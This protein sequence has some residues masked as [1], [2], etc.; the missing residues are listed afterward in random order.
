MLKLD[1]YHYL[2]AGLPELEFNTNSYKKTL[3]EYRN[4]LRKELL[5]NDFEL[6]KILMHEIDNKNLLNI[7][8][9]HPERFLIGGNYSYEELKTNT[10]NNSNLATYLQ[11][12]FL[13]DPFQNFPEK[14]D[15]YTH[16]LFN[17]YNEFT[18]KTKNSFLQLWF[19]FN[20][21]LR[22]IILILNNEK[23]DNGDVLLDKNKTKQ[24]IEKY[25]SKNINQKLFFPWFEK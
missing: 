2:I 25:Q 7:L 3:L 11:D 16:E 18:H 10:L 13:L 5:P 1:K 15:Y 9:K 12:F 20:I 14:P 21:N 23:Q 6:V 8:A 17:L 4:E 19:E 24:I 22:N